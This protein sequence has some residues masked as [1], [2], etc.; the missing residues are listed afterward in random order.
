VKIRQYNEAAEMGPGLQAQVD[1][2]KKREVYIYA[3]VMSNTRKKYVYFQDRKFTAEP[4][5]KAHDLAFRYYGGRREEIA[6]EQ[7]R[8]M[9]VSENGGD[10]ILT[11]IKE[12]DTDFQKCVTRNQIETLE[13]S[14]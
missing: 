13:R 1:M 7:D 8:V 12:F 3:M 2:W 5:V 4:F 10:L 11:E 6:C 14:E 9:A